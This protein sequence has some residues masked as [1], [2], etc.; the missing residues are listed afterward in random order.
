MNMPDSLIGEPL[1]KMMGY[2]EWKTNVPDLPPLMCTECGRYE[3]INEFWIDDE[4]P[5]MVRKVAVCHE[6]LTQILPAATECGLNETAV[7]GDAH[8]KQNAA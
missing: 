4:E 6:C 1:E 3:S 5:G 2:D 8:P 7:R